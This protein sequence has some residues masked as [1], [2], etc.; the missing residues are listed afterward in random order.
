[1][2]RSLY[3]LL[4]AILFGLFPPAAK[5][6]DYSVLVSRDASGYYV[7]KGS[8][9][10]VI[11][12]SSC[13]ESVFFDSATL[14]LVGSSFGTIIFSNGNQCAVNNVYVPATV[15]TGT[16]NVT[17]NSN[18]DG[19]YEFSDQSFLVK[20]IGFEF[21]FYAPATLVVNASS[22]GFASGTIKLQSGLVANTITDLFVQRT[23]IGP[24]PSAPPAAP[25]LVSPADQAVISGST[26][27]FSWSSVASAAGY[28]FYFYNRTTGT[29]VLS[30]AIPPTQTSTGF[31]VNNLG[32]GIYSW[33]VASCLSLAAYSSTN[34]TNLSVTRT[35][36]LLSG[37]LQLS[38]RG[39]IDLDGNNKSAIVVRS[40][41]AQL[42]VARLVN[43]Q[44]QFSALQDPGP[45]FRLIGVGDFFRSGKSDLAFQNTTQGTFGDIK[46][47]RNFSAANEVFW[48]QVK[49][50]WDVQAGGDLDGDGFGDLV[51]RYVVTESPDTGVSY[52]WFT[53]GSTVTQVRK[54]GGAPLD[55][56]LLGAADLNGDGAADM[57]YINP[58]N[59]ARALMATANR[60]CANV[61]IGNI[62]T[63]L[64]ALRLADFT[65]NGRGDILLRDK[66]TGAVSL[67]RL[68]AASLTL[69]SYTGAPDDQNASCTGSSL[70]VISA[71]LP[72]L[73]AD[74]TWQFYASGDFNG[75]GIVDIVWKQANGTLTLWLM[76]AEGA[77]PTVIQ[78]A[79]VAPSGFTVFQNGGPGGTSVVPPAPAPTPEG[80]YVG[81]TSNGYSFNAIVLENNQFWTLYGLL[82]SAGRLNVY[83]MGQGDGTITG[84]AYYSANARDYFYTGLVTS[85]VLS[86]TFAPG[87]SFNG[88]AISSNGTTSFLATVPA[89]SGYDY[90]A[91][92]SLASITG[93]WSGKFI[94]N[95]VGTISIQSSGAFSG[96]SA[97]CT[98][99]GT[100]LPRPS[101]KNIFNVSL[102]FGGAPCLLPGQSAFGIGLTSL[103]SNNQRQLLIG[104]VDNTR[105]AGT[106]LFA[107]R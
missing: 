54:R 90:N 49:Q 105:S 56:T 55:W 7:D 61:L 31:G 33:N 68:N 75:D 45:S 21:A 39:G 10:W 65:G 95:N 97:G 107:V 91:P 48:R 17:V 47:W 100:I 99:T 5:A 36:R 19:W 34:C 25:N 102:T 57:V 80:V 23:A 59:Q 29:D 1:M 96:S 24:P 42:Q 52:V 71:T 86:A 20:A 27:N 9:K 28:S 78:N 2:T 46:I 106:A 62:P 69:P 6:V 18:V 3:V 26:V 82:D 73:T 12:T 44:F 53:N 14:R 37:P 93:F 38:R 72:I 66:S 76:N 60:T 77:A 85:G 63:N 40:A 87:V 15:N 32:P 88:N 64:A 50:V 4:A 35:I 30:P 84:N 70:Q 41:S 79:G 74:P 16:Y 92:A 58:S 89:P 13:F 8:S 101:G 83:G 43:N 22:N 94:D 11:R 104:G 103:L 98:Y 81:S 67:L 51:W